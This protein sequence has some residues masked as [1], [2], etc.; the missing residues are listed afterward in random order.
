MTSLERCLT[1][2][3][4]GVPDR[5][6]VGLLNSI[7][8]ARLSGFRFEEY[9][10]DGG[11]MVEAHLGAWDRYRHDII[12]LDNGVCTLAGAVGCEVEFYGD[13]GSPPWVAGPA[14]ERI[15]DVGSLQ[16]IDVEADGMLAEMIKATGLLSQEVG[17]SVCIS[18]DSD[19]GPFS[20]AAMIIDPQD[21]LVA[22][23]DPDMEVYIEQ[24]LDYAAEQVM[25]YARALSDAGAHVTMIGES[26][27]GPDV[28]SPRVYRRFAQP[29]QQRLITQ[30]KSEGIAMGMHICGDATSII[31]NMVDTEAAFLQVDYKID[32]DVVKD[33]SQGK[34]TLMGALDPSGVLALGTPEEVEAET[35]RQLKHLSRGGGYIL[36]PGCSLPYETPN[37]NID[38]LVETV[39]AHG[40]Y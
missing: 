17:D 28:C 19:Q 11:K 8:A 31:S 33:A 18:A 30:L 27:S 20:L 21:F 13:D 35:I 1:I 32:L 23:L 36:A 3:G 37:E 2:L 24:L 39:R 16:P 7:H 22:L 14:L 26:I 6:A 12:E 40:S 9:C 10:K 15:E 4:G 29:V 5:V 25:T 38:V 34:T